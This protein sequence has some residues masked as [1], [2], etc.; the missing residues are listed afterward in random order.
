MRYI[1]RLNILFFVLF[2]SCKK[3]SKIEPLSEQIPGYEIGEEL[4]AGIRTINDESS[5]AFSYRISGLSTVE[6][7]NFFTGNS[8][9]SQNWVE[10]PSST[11]ARDGLGPLFNSR[12]CSG[13]HLNDGRGEPFSAKGLLLRLSTGSTGSS[14]EPMPDI[15]YGGQLQDYALP[16]ITSEGAFSIFYTEIPGAFAD[17][18]VYSLRAPTYSFSNLN[19]GNMQSG[20]LFSPRIGQQMIGLGLIENIS[21]TDILTNAD[22]TDINMDGIS[23]KA[24]YVYNALTKTTDLGRFGWKA[25]VPN[26]YHQTAGAFIGDLGITSW[27]FKDQN[28]TSVQNDCQNAITGGTPEID[29]IKL[30]YVVLY[31]KVLGVPIRRNYKDEE[32]L[33]GKY[34]FKNAGCDKCHTS[35]FVT[36]NNSDIAALN[37]IIIHPYSDFLVHDMGIGLSDNRADFL[38]KSNEWRTQPL[39]GIGLIKTVNRHT[40]LLHDGRARNIQEAILWHGGEAQMSRDYYFK[41]NKKER[42]SLLKFI[43]S[44]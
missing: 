21:I 34:I 28:C 25:N 32:V 1:F 37:N 5:L 31:T 14:G 44:L 16:N 6:G 19:Y 29:S 23:G 10:A 15:N 26:L 2:F 17:G 39:W 20:I 43:E 36:S 33:K 18:E 4:S 11:S 30:N 24:N 42:S 9:F 7:G 35:K 40:Y 41:L 27:L 3:D 22:E 12:S 8:F 38:A 13:C